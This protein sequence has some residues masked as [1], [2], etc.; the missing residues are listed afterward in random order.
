MQKLDHPTRQ[1]H[2]ISVSQQTDIRP[3]WNR[4][5]CFFRPVVIL[6]SIIVVLQPQRHY[7]TEWTFQTL[8][9]GWFGS[10]RN[11][12]FWRQ[13]WR[14]ILPTEW[15]VHKHRLGTWWTEGTYGSRALSSNKNLKTLHKQPNKNTS[16]KGASPVVYDWTQHVHLDALG[17][18]DQCGTFW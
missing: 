14:V 2:T 7:P 12:F 18:R 8:T 3:V 11:T 15:V 16:S 17:F 4:R 1:N 13:S 6:H 9:T 5:P 10:W